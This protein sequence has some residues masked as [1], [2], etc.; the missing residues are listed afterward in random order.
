MSSDMNIQS[1]NRLMEESRRRNN[2]SSNTRGGEA[3]H[4]GWL[5]GWSP[6]EQQE[7]HSQLASTGA[8]EGTSESISSWNEMTD[9]ALNDLVPLNH[10]SGVD[11][12]D[13]KLHQI[14]LA[15]GIKD[16]LQKDYAS[17]INRQE[18]IV[19]KLA[20]GITGPF[21][22]LAGK[23]SEILI[24]HGTVYQ[25]SINQ[26]DMQVQSGVMDQT[27]RN[28]HEIVLRADLYAGRMTDLEK[29][30]DNLSSE[31]MILQT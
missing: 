18:Q 15:N 16:D 6:R 2:E 31:A 27:T 24:G 10:P 4:H 19:Q 25:D 26:L 28:N 21:P 17:A 29:L 30:L 8:P 13:Y 9:Q 20:T 14:L 1:I 7:N 11:S 5:H 12:R 23:V 22:Q 3:A